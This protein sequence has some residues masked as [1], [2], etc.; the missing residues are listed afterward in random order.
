MSLTLAAVLILGFVT[1]QRLA[2]WLSF[3]WRSAIARACLSRGPW[4][5]EQIIMR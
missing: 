3:G 1:V 2:G 4:N 5:L